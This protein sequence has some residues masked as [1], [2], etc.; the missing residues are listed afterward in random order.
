[1]FTKRIWLLIGAL[2]I[3]SAGVIGA[4]A[5]LLKKPAPVMEVAEGEN[6]EES[7]FMESEEPTLTEPEIILSN[8]DMDIS[9]W[10]TCTNKEYGFEIKYPKEI[11]G[12][13]IKLRE[14][15]EAMC[16]ILIYL[17]LPYLESSWEDLTESIVGI[18]GYKISSDEID[19]T[20]RMFIDEWRERTMPD[21]ESQVEIII[22][23]N[24]KA[25][26]VSSLNR[27][28]CIGDCD[29]D[30]GVYY[31]IPDY[32]QNLLVVAEGSFT[33]EKSPFYSDPL[34]WQTKNLCQNQFREMIIFEKI[35]STFRFIK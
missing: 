21:L 32:D 22:P 14:D 4:S 5:Y 30:L 31:Y 16:Q 10:K 13:E 9:N 8:S 7:I 24:I 20:I 23:E 27:Y 12:A 1:M 28:N 15:K 2:T 6:L 29:E 19:G 17:E 3:L 33:I 11:T 35:I 34:Y 25:R 18:N 26:K